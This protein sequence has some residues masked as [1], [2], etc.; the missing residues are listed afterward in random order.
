MNKKIKKIYSEVKKYNIIGT[1]QLFTV[2]SIGYMSYVV[3]LGTDG[4]VPTIMSAPALIYASVVL[5]KKFNN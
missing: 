5:V 3:I 2:V 1:L 4:I